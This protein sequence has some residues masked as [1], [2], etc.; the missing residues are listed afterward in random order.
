[1]GM[2]AAWVIGRGAAALRAWRRASRRRLCRGSGY[3]VKTAGAPGKV[4]RHAAAA[5]APCRSGASRDRV[6]EAQ[7]FARNPIGRSA[8]MAVSWRIGRRVGCGCGGF[9]LAPASR[10]R[11]R[12]LRRSYRGLRRVFCAVV[13]SEVGF[14]GLRGAG[15][16][17]HRSCLHAPGH[18]RAPL[19]PR[20]RTP[21]SPC[22]AGVAAE[23]GVRRRRSPRA[24]LVNCS[25]PIAAAS[26]D[27][28]L[29]RC[30]INRVAAP[31]RDLSSATDPAAVNAFRPI[32]SPSA[33]RRYAGGCR[34]A[35][36]R[37]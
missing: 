25:P 26:I 28:A 24:G 15:F 35:L 7:A 21:P 2:T 20:P 10:W 23:Q 12:G 29:S 16:H 6:N 30:N 3:A 22:A 33:N 14:R 17:N 34:M 13:V 11:G 36:C 37:R 27:I 1:M 18:R 8:S 4:A 19:R 31:R 9:E 5:I 32:C